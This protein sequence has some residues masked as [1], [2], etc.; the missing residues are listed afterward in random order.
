M[1]LDVYLT[2]ENAQNTGEGIFIREGGRTKE[3]SRAE[4]DKRFPEREPLTAPYDNDHVYEA[5]I[6]HNLNAMAKEANI[7][8]ALWRPEELGFSK[9]SQLIGPLEVGLALL[10][11]DP[12]RFKKFDPPNGWGDY[13][14]FVIFVGKYLKACMQFPEAEV[15]VSR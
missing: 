14:G 5:N 3:I 6:T 1:S 8:Y 15:S 4:W 7:Y 11:S 10:L 9:A 12:E 2:M 13:Y